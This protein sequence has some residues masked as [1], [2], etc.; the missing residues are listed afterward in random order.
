M[1]R[2]HKSSVYVKHVV[3]YVETGYHIQVGSEMPIIWSM[4]RP[5]RLRFSALFPWDVGGISIECTWV[6]RVG[7]RYET[8]RILAKIVDMLSKISKG[9]YFSPRSDFVAPKYL[10]FISGLTFDHPLPCEQLRNHEMTDI[11][12]SPI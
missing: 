2:R 1:I 3:V 4:D 8:S 9:I 6:A 12:I 10:R 7:S 5:S 11:L